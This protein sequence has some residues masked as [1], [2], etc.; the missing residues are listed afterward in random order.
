LGTPDIGYHANINIELNAPDSNN[1]PVGEEVN[2]IH[3]LEE[4]I[5]VGLEEANQSILVARWF[6]PEGRNLLFY[7]ADG[8]SL[9]RELHDITIDETSHQVKVKTWQ[10]EEWNA[11]RIALGPDVVILAN[12]LQWLGENNTR[13]DLLSEE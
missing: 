1:L 13:R 9:V 12:L 6:A 4:R 3:Q 8:W 11:F 5:Q 10:D 2:Q 7:A